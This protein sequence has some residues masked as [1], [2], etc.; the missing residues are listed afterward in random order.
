MGG[1]LRIDPATHTSAPELRRIGA[2]TYREHFASIWSPAALENYLADQ[3]DEVRIAT[4][5]RSGRTCYLVATLGPAADA[6]LP[7]DT[8]RR[9]VGYCKVNFDRPDPVNGI[10]GME[11]E[12]IYLA[13]ESTGRGYGAALM[14]AVFD[15]ANSRKQLTVWLDVLQTNVAGRRMYERSG[16]TVIGEQP[17]ATDIQTIG[18]WVMRASRASGITREG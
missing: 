18:F 9:V 13:P 3:F 17:F 11:L 15:L 5:I 2:S 16:F 7:M 14:G 8:Q 12:K 1:F 4:E 6:D 10:A